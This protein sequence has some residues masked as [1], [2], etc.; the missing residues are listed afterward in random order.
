MNKNRRS[1]KGNKDKDQNTEKIVYKGK[2]HGT[3]KSYGFVELLDKVDKTDKMQDI[4]VSDSNNKAGAITNDDVLV[5]VVQSHDFRTKTGIEG[6]IHEV[7]KRNFNWCI[8]VLKIKN[9]EYFVHSD[10]KSGGLEIFITRKNLNG[11]KL[12]NLVKV[13]LSSVSS[14]TSPKKSANIKGRKK[15]NGSNKK[16]YGEVEQVLGERDSASANYESILISHGIKTQFGDEAI[17]LSKNIAI[18]TEDIANREDLRDK[19]IFTIDG[20]TA[21]DLDD[22]ISIDIDDEK[23]YILGVHIADVS[24]YVSRKSPLDLEAYERG[25]SVYFIDKV[26]PMLPEALSNGICSLNEGEDRLCLSVFMTIDKNGKTVKSRFEHTLINSKI[27]GIYSEIN[28]IFA[29]IY[30]AE[31][32]KDQSPENIAELKNKYKRVLPVLRRVKKLAEILKKRRV[33]NGALELESVESEFIMTYDN[34]TGEPKI[35]D[36]IKLPAGES[37]G[38]IEEFMLKANE[39]VAEFLDGMNL[40]CVYRV[41]EKP[42][43]DKIEAFTA[44]LRRLGYSSGSLKNL[45]NK[46][47]EIQPK[48]LQKILNHY[49]NTPLFQMINT[50]MLRSLAKAR[51]SAENFGHFGLASEKYCHFTSPIRRYPDLLNHRII[52]MAMTGDK[53][54]LGSKEFKYFTVLAANQSTEKEMNAVSAEREIEDLYKTIYMSEH[55]GETYTGVISSV[56]SFGV[57]V[58]LENTCEGLVHI[59]DMDG[60]F[61][62]DS[63][64]LELY[65]DFKRYSLGQKVQIKVVG[66]N[67]SE[68]TVNFIFW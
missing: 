56:T 51:Y 7:V 59:S 13:K 9:G 21:K 4:F 12:D 65:N 40:P 50:H 6:I 60:Y 34:K 39:T 3:S 27:K 52:K 5:E 63:S 8:G 2:Y 66:A 33:K 68:G 53:K 46:E 49:R 18:N 38:I 42:F 29:D 45:V 47:K 20:I 55:I 22:A 67:I 10:K 35:S 32:K 26:V 16:L 43:Y 31:E 57:F 54:T 25:T 41:H 11:A 62:F 1:N 23:N 36:I 28:E 19:M 37:E 14:N 17:E 61:E 58:I 24:H 48:D 30:D 64:S 44:M 15:I